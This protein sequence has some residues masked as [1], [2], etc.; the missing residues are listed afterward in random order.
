MSKVQYDLA[1]LCRS[2]TKLIIKDILTILEIVGEVSSG[3][4]LTVQVFIQQ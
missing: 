1:N 3:F 4:M 2:T